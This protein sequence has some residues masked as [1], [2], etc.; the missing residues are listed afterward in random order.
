MKRYRII[1]E[2][3]PDAPA[4]YDDLGDLLPALY[5]KR[6]PC[7]FHFHIVDRNNKWLFPV[8]FH[9]KKRFT[10]QAH[11]TRANREPPG[12]RKL[13]ILVQCDYRSISKRER[14]SVGKGKSV[15]ESEN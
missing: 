9:I 2:P 12:V 8:G 6:S 3:Y 7:H 14:K 1:T 13:R 10:L 11:C 4:F 5:I 15:S